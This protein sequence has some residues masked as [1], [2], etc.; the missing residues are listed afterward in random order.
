M[1]D[2]LAAIMVT[3]TGVT[4]LAVAVCSPGSID[5]GR[6]AHGYHPLFHVLLMGVSMA[7]LTGDLFNL[8]VT[9][10]VMLMASF[11]LL[12]LGRS[13]PGSRAPSGT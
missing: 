13:G 10:E 1:A 11:V 9:F 7:F 3:L 2:L 6:E 12:S 5:A 4:G 8:Y